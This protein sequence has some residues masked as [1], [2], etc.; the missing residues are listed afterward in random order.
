M[1][2][3]AYAIVIWAMSVAPMAHVVALRETSV[4]MA[5][6]IGSVALKESFGMRRIMAAAVVALGVA[7]LQLG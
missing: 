1:S 5:A 2:S 3:L 6:L 7:M 4:V